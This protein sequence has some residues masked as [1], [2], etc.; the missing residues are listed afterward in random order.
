MEIIQQGI[1]HP[2]NLYTGECSNCHCIIRVTEDEITY[3][4]NR[5]NNPYYDC[6]TSG[7]SHIIPVKYTKTLK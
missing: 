6:P 1:I 3:Q 5:I 4:Y 2:V 7:C